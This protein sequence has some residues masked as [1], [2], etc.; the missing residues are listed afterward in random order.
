MKFRFES[1]R[2][3]MQREEAPSLFFVRVS[4]KRVT[5]AKLNCVTT[6]ELSIVDGAGKITVFDESKE[7]LTARAV[8]G[9]TVTNFLQSVRGCLAVG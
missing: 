9:S 5:R 8:C 1:G 4:N 2:I 7:I 6:E 3:K